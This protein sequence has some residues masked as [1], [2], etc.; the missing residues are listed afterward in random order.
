MRMTRDSR[1]APISPAATDL[2]LATARSV[3]TP[4]D[5]ARV[6]RAVSEITDWTAVVQ[7]AL[8]H[9]TAG[10]LCHHMLAAAAD[11][12]PGEIGGAAEAYVA[13]RRTEH[14]RAV[15]NLGLVLNALTAAG[16][17]ALPYK[18]LVL[19]AL[20]HADPALRG[21]RDLDVLIKEDDIA[22][23]MA[24]L[25][26]L[27]YRSLQ[28][29]LSPRRMREFYAYNG[30]DVLIAEGL[31]PVEPHWRLNPRT[32]HA[33]I[34]TAS[35]VACAVTVTLNGRTF[36][37]PS[38]EDTLLICG[39]HGSKEEW[40]RLI[41]VA[42]VAELLRR[43]GDLDWAAILSRASRAGV[44]RML[45][46]GIALASG[47][48]GVTIPPRAAEA[49]AEDRVAQKLA[50]Q[51]ADRLFVRGGL[52]PSVYHLTGFRLRV[53]ERL[54]DRVRYVTATLLTARVQHFRF[55]DLPGGLAV[56]Y[57]LVRIGHDYVALPLWRL[58][59][60]KVPRA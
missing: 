56:L 32:L 3:L 10:L 51:A 14:D 47:I 41:W 46:T 58:T 59:R 29:G 4:E 60:P 24:A 49:L 9:G 7:A 2:L 52:T 6:R 55:V 17:S 23:A 12:L 42:D 36:P 48:L 57:P 43:A 35:L 45:L 39:M 8:D 40:S 20:C 11:L 50:H 5:A 18:G 21:C 28:T 22:A 30:Q 27:G 26:R 25:R 33:D 38:R 54:R 53:R 31:M 13:F 34:D 16:V 19:A 37:S 44:R 1:Q 15:R